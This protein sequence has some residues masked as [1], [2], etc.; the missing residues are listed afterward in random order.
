MSINSIVE[1]VPCHDVAVHELLALF[2]IESP[3]FDLYDD[4]SQVGHFFD[5]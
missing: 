1:A 4:C 2:A 3:D 5:E